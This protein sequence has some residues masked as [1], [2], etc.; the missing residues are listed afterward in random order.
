MLRKL[1]F[2][3]STL[4]VLAAARADPVRI[5]YQTSVA[6]TAVAIVDGQFARDS[7]VP[8]EWRR[9]DS[10]A[11][12]VRAMASGDID[13]GSVG[14]SLVAAAAARELP[15]ETFLIASQLGI[16]EA[17]VVRNGS[18]IAVPQD[19]V[20]K[21]VAVPFVSTCH[22]SLLA[23]LKHWGIDR[24]RVKIVNLR[25]TEIPAAWMRGD[26]D[27]AYVWDPALGR[28]K[29]T[30]TVLATSVDAARWGAPTYDVW[31][32]RKDFSARH[33]PFLDAFARTSLELMRRYAADP[34]GFAG[35]AANLAAIVKATG[36]KPEDVPAM[37][38]GNTYP[39]A[40]EQRRLLDGGFVVAL[41]DTAAFLKDQ[42]K[43]DVVLP[44]Y[45]AYS[46]ARF[47]PTAAVAV[48]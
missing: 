6:P 41:A 11:E 16:S 46:T 21:T 15:V 32:V 42:G 9:F 2:L 7:G 29:E 20:G 14:S 48:R 27:A 39:Q 1:V 45:H 25:P 38:G 13:I 43:I 40:D 33:A 37:L 3:C 4:A 12:V 5:G 23:A 31:I 19:L 30:G 28:I 44:D 26:I 35:S 24:A 34:R 36:A 47:L 10:G 17:L 8:I 22:Y 18:G